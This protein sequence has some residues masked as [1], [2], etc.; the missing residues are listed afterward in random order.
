MRNGLRATKQENV[1]RKIFPQYTSHPRGAIR[2]TGATAP[3][4]APRAGEI[5]LARATQAAIA[6]VPL[7]APDLRVL[8]GAASPRMRRSGYAARCREQFPGNQFAARV[9]PVGGRLRIR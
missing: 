4:G 5:P 6:T 7:H 3:A 2:S 8:S 1:L 9:R